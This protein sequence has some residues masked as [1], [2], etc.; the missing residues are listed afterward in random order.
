MTKCIISVKIKDDR[1]S[2][3]SQIILSGGI[4]ENTPIAIPSVIIADID[5]NIYDTLK[6]NTK[7]SFIEWEEFGSTSVVQN[8]TIN[9]NYG[10]DRLDQ[11]TLPLSGHYTYIRSGFNTD[12]YVFD[13]GIN[14]DHVEFSGRAVP[15]YDGINDITYPNGLDGN[16]HGTHIAAII[17][18][19]T[20][21]VAKQAK[22]HSVKIANRRGRV[23]ST[24][25]MNGAIA[26]ISDHTTKSSIRH[27]VAN[28]SL[29]FYP[30][31]KTVELAV[32]SMIDAGII[33]VNSAGNNNVNAETSSPTY[34]SD[35]LAVGSI[36]SLDQYSYF[37]NYGETVDVFAPGADILSASAF[38]S[39]S[40]IVNHLSS[41]PTTIGFVPAG[42]ELKYVTAKVIEPFDGGISQISVGYMSHSLFTPI[43][44]SGTQLQ[45]VGYS[46]EASVNFTPT[47][48]LPIVALISSNSIL[49]STGKLEVSFFIN[50][51]TNSKSI[52]RDGTS[53]SCA[54]ASGVVALRLEEEPTKLT[55]RTQVQNIKQYIVDSATKFQIQYFPQE[56]IDSNTPDR[57]LFS[58]WGKSDIVEWITQSGN[59]TTLDEGDVLSVFVEAV[60]YNP[61]GIE[62]NDIVYSIVSSPTWG[63]TTTVQINPTTGEITWDGPMPL[64][65]N[66]ET[67]SFTIRA[68]STD[69]T[70]VYNDRTFSVAVLNIPNIPPAWS[71]PPDYQLPLRGYVTPLPDANEATAYTPFDL[72]AT[73][74]ETATEVQDYKILTGSLPPGLTLNQTTGIISGTIAGG[75][76]ESKNYIFVVRVTDV[77][78][79]IVDR[80]FSINLIAQEASPVWVTP[81]GNIGTANIN[82]A[83]TFLL[84]ATDVDMDPVTYN[85]VSG[86]LPNGLTLNSS[87]G[88]IYGTPIDT[89]GI[90][91]FTIEATDGL[92]NTLR[93][94]ELT[95][96]NLL[97]NSPPI[98]ITPIGSLGSMNEA[99][100]SSF[101]VQAIDPDGD[102]LTYTLSL[103]LGQT[104]PPGLTL[105]SNG[106]ITGIADQV[107]VDTTHFFTVAVSDG[108]NPSVLRTFSITVLNVIGVVPP[109]W[110]TPAG[111]LG[112][113]WEFYPSTVG[114]KATDPNSLPLTYSIIDGALPSG[115]L[116]SEDTGLIYSIPDTVSVDTIST[117]TIRVSNGTF[118]SDRIFSITILNII[119]QAVTKVV[120]DRITGYNRKHVR[121]FINS[122]LPPDQQ[123]LLYRVGDPE[124]AI[125]IEFD[126]YLVQ[127]IPLYPEVFGAIVDNV[128]DPVDKLLEFSNNNIS[129]AD[130]FYTVISDNIYKWLNP[131]ESVDPLYDGPLKV[132]HEDDSDDVNNDQRILGGHYYKSKVLLGKLEI[133]KARD[134]FTG[135][136]LY[137][138][139]ISN[140]NDPSQESALLKKNF[141]PDVV[142]Y[143]ETT[144]LV[145]SSSSD[146]EPDPGIA[147]GPEYPAAYQNTIMPAEGAIYTH[148][149]NNA[150]PYDGT[151]LNAG[152]FPTSTNDDWRLVL[153]RNTESI[154]FITPHS[155]E[156]MRLHIMEGY[157]GFVDDTELKPLWMGTPQID[158]E[159]TSTVIWRPAI[160]LAYL[161]P[162]TGEEFLASLSE[163]QRNFLSG[164][165]IIIERHLV[166]TTPILTP[167]TTFGDQLT[168]TTFDSETT[169]FSGS[170]FDVLTAIPNDCTFDSN[171]TVFDGEGIRLYN[172]YIKFPPGDKYWDAMKNTMIH[173]LKKQ[174]PAIDIKE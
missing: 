54:F 26:V 8:I 122:I 77:A 127:G 107:T 46:E 93:S 99:S 61:I 4:V 52:S 136:H 75:I 48:D 36:D 72:H 92:L 160:Q 115:L 73:D 32:E 111:S 117:F 45:L 150:P 119:G 116:L 164:Y 31:N 139:L 96:S 29:N 173:K 102:P 50:N 104:F 5:Q 7:I 140:I 55:T 78:G 138:I 86:T 146:G 6:N 9:D 90:Y 143:N 25:I 19:I 172:K 158:G 154:N 113:L 152:N 89:V 28:M 68:S 10:L 105:N 62:T 155:I 98:W 27:S 11:K 15:F 20:Y 34:L 69:A 101:I 81:A 71:N 42:V 74:P 66:N 121:E 84:V 82:I 141:R 83:F 16:G 44:M 97:V 165:P 153:P 149:E 40:T 157:G 174:L 67:R 108:I 80:T 100:V 148:P 18:G 76:L 110:I 60:Y 123:G 51:I 64:V 168:S 24:A 134:K 95:L 131:G 88:L 171:T 17:G 49:T 125:P 65:S 63:G 33:V 23:S 91:S 37:S 163:E 3:V 114:V 14:Y 129:P 94:F 13:S 126:I 145:T 120:A 56:A 128:G 22:L 30:R 130:V 159:P 151:V 166:S 57:I 85:L 169:L 118:S 142:T 109:I 47:T 112:E 70:P 59:L 161:Q 132:I 137:D 147:Y 58:P 41:S 170:T 21:G 43:S 39:E 144:G 133:F 106:F 79:G 1:N 12:V 35:V 156:N 38:H 103:G 167:T 124:F 2:I 162:G 135:E 53:Q 87:T